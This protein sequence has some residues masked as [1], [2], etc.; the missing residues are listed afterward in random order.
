MYARRSGVPA[1]N[2]CVTDEEK[3]SHVDGEDMLELEHII[4]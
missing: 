1:I 3:E 2:N 4:G